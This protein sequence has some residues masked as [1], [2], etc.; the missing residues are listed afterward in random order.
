MPA[1][2]STFLLI[3]TNPSNEIQMP[4]VA[5]S[6]C[7]GDERKVGHRVDGGCH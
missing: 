3:Q 1:F 4:I 2:L 5:G 6:L 7:E